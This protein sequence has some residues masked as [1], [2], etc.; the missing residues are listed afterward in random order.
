M[1]S[2]IQD[3]RK[4]ISFLKSEC[5]ALEKANRTSAKVADVLKKEVRRLE[6]LLSAERNGGVSN[7][8]C[9]RR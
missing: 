4:K 8:S 9:T 7:K 6:E 3:R 2:E 1:D 5:E